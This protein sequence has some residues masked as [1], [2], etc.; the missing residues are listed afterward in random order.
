MRRKRR[1]A[2]PRASRAADELAR[3]DELIAEIARDDGKEPGSAVSG[4]SSAPAAHTP[5]FWCLCYFAVVMVNGKWEMIVL[6]R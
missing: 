2:T 6:V 3:A 5:F 1:R 4:A